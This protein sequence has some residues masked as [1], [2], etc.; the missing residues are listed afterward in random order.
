MAVNDRTAPGSWQYVGLLLRCTIVGFVKVCC[1][2]DC[3]R[4]CLYTGSPSRQTIDGCVYNGL[5]STEPGKL[6]DIKLSSDESRFNL[7]D[8]DG[9][10]RVRRYAGECC[11]AECVIE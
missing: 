2:M 7:W 1:T 8:H 11:L 4:G 6:I 3:V 10:I 9:R 5:M